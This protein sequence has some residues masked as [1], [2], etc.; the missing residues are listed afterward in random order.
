MLLPSDHDFDDFC[1]MMI[2]IMMVA[3]HKRFF[4]GGLLVMRYQVTLFFPLLQLYPKRMEITLQIGIGEQFTQR[5]GHNQPWPLHLCHIAAF[6]NI[7][8]HS[9]LPSQF[10]LFHFQNSGS[11]PDPAKLSAQEHKNGV[12]LTLNLT[13]NIR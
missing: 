13:I 3:F 4:S 12:F 11:A 6:F 7:L 1:N 8:Y 10:S 2:M 5:Y 9:F